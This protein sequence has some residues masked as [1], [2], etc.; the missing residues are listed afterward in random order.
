MLCVYV[1]R[2]NHKS[3]HCMSVTKDQ[4]VMLFSETIAV[5]S[6][7]HTKHINTF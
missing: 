7:K 3:A 6:E 4:P 5:Y 2:E 1:Y